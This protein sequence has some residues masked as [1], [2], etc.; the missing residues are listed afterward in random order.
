MD[1]AEANEFADAWAQAWN[2][3][4]LDRVLEHWV[5]LRRSDSHESW[6]WPVSR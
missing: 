3:H 2:D 6:F 5:R 4:D 1:L